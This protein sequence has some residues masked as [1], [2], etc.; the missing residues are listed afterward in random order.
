[1]T[2][3]NVFLPL[4]YLGLLGSII[5]CSNQ[6]KKNEDQLEQRIVE[7][8]TETAAISYLLEKRLHL[9]RFFE[10]SSDPYFG[11]TT[12]KN[13]KNNID[14]RANI[15]KIT[16]GKYFQVQILVNN[17][18]AI[19]DCLKENNTQNAIYQYV[20]CGNKVLETKLFYPYDQTFSTLP[21]PSCS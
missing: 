21:F 13:C 4:V 11:T 8:K 19:G 12:E 16:N 14:I 9:L 10:L 20:Q 6:N 17:Y 3:K 1:M 5:S 15:I 18:H 2:Y 7:L